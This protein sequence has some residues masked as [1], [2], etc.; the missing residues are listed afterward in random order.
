M[1]VGSE[2]ALDALNFCNAGI[3]TGLG[4]FIAIFY[5]AVR[6]WGPGKIGLL[7]ALQSLAGILIQPFIGN[8]FDETRH[9][10]TITA[11][12]AIAVAIGAFT[13]AVSPS[14][15]VQAVAQVIIG[16]AVTA[17]PA[18]TSAFALGLTRGKGLTKRIARNEVFTHSGNVIFAIVAGIVGALA[19][20]ADI[21]YA[22]AIFALGMAV[23][24]AFV[25]DG[26]VNY[27]AA[28]AGEEPGDGVALQRR[29]LHELLKDR[30]VVVFTVAI[31]LF[32]GSNAATLPLVGQ[33]FADH[34]G[35][36]GDVGRCAVPTALAVLVA[37][38]VMV[39]V[40]HVVGRNADD[41]WGRKIPFVVAFGV[42]ALRNVLGIVSHAPSYLVALQTL[43]G[44][45][46]STYGVLLTLVTADL[47][48]R[49]GRFNALQGTVQSAMALGGF[50]SNLGFGVLAQRY[51]YNASFIG[52]AV[53]AVAGG[54]LYARAMPETRPPRIEAPAERRVPIDPVHRPTP[55]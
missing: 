10:R 40:A 49:T 38:V 7:L 22:A 24:V 47:A 12:A 41:G 11:A 28:R 35:A 2:R 42:L 50:L 33:I 51:G 9:K 52:L 31:I 14:F 34:F 36:G 17:I 18:A 30:R 26:E 1:K 25:S 19:S 29:H 37:E 15:A 20:L 45:A 54:L 39:P 32:F 5:G 21:F 23:A 44:V 13:I 43:D 8:L 4:P 27:E 48:A 55:T 53:V 16:V 46:A 3:Q 6:H